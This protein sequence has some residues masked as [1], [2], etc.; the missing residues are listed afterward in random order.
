[1]ETSASS[2]TTEGTSLYAISLP[3]TNPTV[4]SAPTSASSASTR[5]EY[6]T[7]TLLW[8]YLVYP[9]C[10]A[11]L[12]VRDSMFPLYPST[13]PSRVQMLTLGVALAMARVRDYV[14]YGRQWLQ[15]RLAIAWGSSYS[16]SS[17]SPPPSVL[18]SPD[19]S[20]LAL[21]GPQHSMA[22]TLEDSRSFLARQGDRQRLAHLVYSKIMYT[23][24]RCIIVIL[25]WLYKLRA[26][27]RAA[28][29]RSPLIVNKKSSHIW[30]LRSIETAL[31][32]LL[33]A[34]PLRRAASTY[35][36]VRSLILPAP[37]ASRTRRCTTLTSGSGRAPAVKQTMAPAF[38][39]DAS[40]KPRPLMLR[41]WPPPLLF[42]DP[43]SIVP[44]LRKVLIYH[45][46][47]PFSV[48]RYAAPLTQLHQP[49]A[50]VKI[51]DISDDEGDTLYYC[52]CCDPCPFCD[53]VQPTA[54]PA[55]QAP[56]ARPFALPRIPLTVPVIVFLLEVW[57]QGGAK[58]LLLPY[59]IGIALCYL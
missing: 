3:T 2:F 47:L 39:L 18:S 16:F 43:P 49:V 29:C 20:E 26:A 32:L 53:T 17:S 48:F 25:S 5:A 19:K 21:L 59:L 37:L 30:R 57:I 52:P 36:T 28:S 55:A 9:F 40:T 15:A 4:T 33:A 42:A 13:G 6:S 56:N 8:Y 23:Y 12:A 35:Y 38:G 1:M 45:G 22:R 51:E 7:F 31:D 46:S 34:R 58:N 41:N 54:A 27:R 44:S 24:H 11:A 50:Q 10:K 14:A